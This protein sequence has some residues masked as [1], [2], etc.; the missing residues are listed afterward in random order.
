MSSK[1]VLLAG[2]Y[3]GKWMQSRHFL[4]RRSKKSICI[5][6]ISVLFGERSVE[7][8]IEPI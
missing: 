1:I 7:R 8:Q 4:I 6:R 2:A 3:S 5:L